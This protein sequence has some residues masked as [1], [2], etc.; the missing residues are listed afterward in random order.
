MFKQYKERKVDFQASLNTPRVRL[1]ITRRRRRPGDPGARP[2]RHGRQDSRDARTRSGSDHRP[3]VRLSLTE[4]FVKTAVVDR[5]DRK[6]GVTSYR[7]R[8][9]RVRRARS[10]STRASVRQLYDDDYDD[11][12]DDARNA[13]RGRRDARG[14]GVHAQRRLENPAPGVLVLA[15]VPGPKVSGDWDEPSVHGLSSGYHGPVQLAEVYLCV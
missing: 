5:S 7:C 15:E 3:S 14:W 11:A 1:S 10:R 2:R 13:A 4:D 6:D 12:R 8:C 9:R